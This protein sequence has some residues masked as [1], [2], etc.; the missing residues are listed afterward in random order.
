MTSASD[1]H[2]DACYLC[3]GAGGYEDWD[4]TWQTC[5]RCDG[6]GLTY[7]DECDPFQEFKPRYLKGM[8]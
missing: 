4:G 5:S 1:H 6:A 7:C 8:P 2:P 3:N